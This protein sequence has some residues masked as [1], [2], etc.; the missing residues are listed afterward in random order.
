ML[1]FLNLKIKR[2]IL[3]LEFNVCLVFYRGVSL[4]PNLN[5]FFKYFLLHLIVRGMHYLAYYSHSIIIPSK[6]EGVCIAH[7]PYSR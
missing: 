3:L 4:L 1:D 6:T 5:L 7:V 2:S